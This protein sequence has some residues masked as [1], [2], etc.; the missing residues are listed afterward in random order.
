MHL[1]PDLIRVVT[2]FAWDVSFSDRQLQVQLDCA[3]DCQK[4][5]PPWFL[6]DVVYCFPKDGRKKRQRKKGSVWTL[7]FYNPLV[8]GAPYRPF[9]I[10]KERLNRR[11]CEWLFL[12]IDSAYLKRKR[13]HRK[14]LSRMLDMPLIEAWAK[15]LEKVGDLTKQDTHPIGYVA[16]LV[17]Q[18]MLL[19]LPLSGQLSNWTP[20]FRSFWPD[21]LRVG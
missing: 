7:K 12:S 2:Q 5:I 16:S 20:L 6:E 19:H 9:D 8:F 21:G 3:I 10:R 4:N 1:P 17:T 13:M 14:P 15:L 11:S 18:S